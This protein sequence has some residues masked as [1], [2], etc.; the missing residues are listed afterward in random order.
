MSADAFLAAIKDAPADDSPRLVYADWLDDQGE[1]ERAEFIRVQVALAKLN[2]ELQSDED[3]RDPKC[4]G[5]KERRDLH[6]RGRKLAG[7]VRLPPKWDWGIATEGIDVPNPP[8]VWLDRGF[9]DEAHCPAPDWFAHAAALLAAHPLRDVHLTTRAYWPSPGGWEELVGLPF[10]TAR[11]P[12][13]AFHLPPANAPAHRN[14]GTADA[15]EW[16]EWL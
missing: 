5:C 9:V 16:V 3:C 7:S 13:I 10:L 14:V 2:A 8:F 15:P 6:A 12:G 11:W 4:I 1:T